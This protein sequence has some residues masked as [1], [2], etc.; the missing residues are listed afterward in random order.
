MVSALLIADL[1]GQYEKL[2]SFLNLN[3]D[4]VIISGDITHFGPKEQALMVTSLIDVPCFVVPGNCDPR[5]I[6]EVFEDS[7]A[8]SLHGSALTLGKLSLVG[9]GGSNPGPFQCPFVLTEV[10]ID[11]ILS[12][13]ISVMDRNMYNVL[14]SHAP[15]KGTLDYINNQHVGSAS[16]AKHMK[17]FD[18]ICCA[19][20][21]E[22]RGC[23]DVKGVKVVNPGT[24]SNGHCAL[25][26][27][28][29]SEKNIQVELKTV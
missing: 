8:V 22:E 29:E 21:H 16:I 2:D 10:E 1:H 19:H 5:D 23:V 3:Y 28:N 4:M 7:S 11:E 17:S 27:F 24:A 9:L 26:H 13:A 6:L 25:I 15:P 18:L 14:V 20:I 12:N